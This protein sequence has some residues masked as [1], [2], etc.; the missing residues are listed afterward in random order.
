MPAHPCVITRLCPPCPGRSWLVG[1]FLA[2]VVAGETRVQ[3]RP[4]CVH[5]CCVQRVSA[6]S[7][8][9]QCSAVHTSHCSGSNRL[10]LAALTLPLLCPQSGSSTCRC[11]TC[12]CCTCTSAVRAWTATGQC[13]PA[14]CGRGQP[15]SNLHKRCVGVDSHRA[16]VTRP[17]CQPVKWMLLCNR[18]P[19][20]RRTPAILDRRS[21]SSTLQLT[22]SP[23][24]TSVLSA[25]LSVPQHFTLPPRARL[26]AAGLPH[27]VHRPCDR[28]LPGHPLLCRQ[29]RGTPR[30]RRGALWAWLGSAC[31]CV[32]AWTPPAKASAMVS[33]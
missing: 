20:C 9:Q 19:P 3:R 32:Q 29:E 27:P 7:Q 23:V 1:A 2:I 21:P 14:L 6:A 13:A 18:R 10:T 24:L 15:Q 26:Q 30:R 11:S 31:P 5:A 8:L 17:A 33:S 16:C 4:C 12:E 22:A 28:P 25:C